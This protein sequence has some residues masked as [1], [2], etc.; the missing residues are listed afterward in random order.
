MTNN[1]PNHVRGAPASFS[2]E[3]LDQLCDILAARLATRQAG[4]PALHAGG[5]RFESCT[6][7]H[8]LNFSHRTCH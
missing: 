6:A 7:H 4:A 5:R 1:N 2:N 8:R 3:E